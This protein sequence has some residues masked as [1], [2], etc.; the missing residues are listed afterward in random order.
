M[1]ELD[2]TCK[3]ATP[4]SLS[5][6]TRSASTALRQHM[7]RQ[8]IVALA[9]GALAVACATKVFDHPPLPSGPHKEALPDGGEFAV[10]RGVVKDSETG[11]PIRDAVIVL[12]C[13]GFADE[14]VAE[15]SSGVYRFHDVPAGDCTV[16]VLHG[17][18][19][20]SRSL[21]VEPGFAFRLDI[22]VDPDTSFIRT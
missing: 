9:I 19:T 22:V 3:L 13:S 17:R 16:Q 21:A 12:Q 1:S 6:D 4:S 10:L 15:T 11:E 20:A 2:N 7:T 5:S 14:R 18:A 8:S